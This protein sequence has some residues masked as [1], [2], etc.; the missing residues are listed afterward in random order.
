M[1]A[2]VGDTDERRFLQSTPWI[3]DAHPQGPDALVTALRQQTDR[4]SELPRQPRFT[5]LTML[6]DC[7]LQHL[8]ELILSVRCQSYQNW[9]LVLVDDGSTTRKR[10]EFAQTWADRDERIHVRDIEIPFGP[11][12][13]KNLAMEEATGDFLIVTDGDGVLHPMALGVFARHLNEDPNVN[14][15]F[16]NEAEIDHSSTGLTNFL[17]KPPLD[18]FT[19]LRVPYIGRLCAMGRD[20]VDRATQGGGPIFRD[21]YDGIEE[22]DLSLRLALTSGF[23]SRHVPL[24]TYYRRAGSHGQ[25][26]LTDQK[27]VERRR[28][29]AEEFIPRVYPGS[30]WSLTVR[31]DRD[32][33][34]STSIWLKDVPGWTCPKLLVVIPFKDQVETTIQC[35]ESIERQ[36]HQLDVVVALVNNQSS[37]EETLPRLRLWIESPRAAKYQIL[38]HDGAFN[39][40]RLNNE[41]VARL[42]GDRDLI[43]LLNNDVELSTPQTLETLAMQLLADRSIGFVGI[44]LVYPGGEE[45][46]HG[47]VRVGELIYGSGFYEIKHECNAQGFVDAD[48]ISLGVTFACAMTRRRTYE[49]L[50]GL[51]ELYLPNGYGDVDMC[52]RALDAGFRNYYL[53]SLTAI[54]HESKSRGSTNEDI[55]ISFLHQRKGQT[56]ASWRHLHLSRS[57]RYAWPLVVLRWDDPRSSLLDYVSQPMPAAF[58]VDGTTPSP[59][60]LRYRLA[61]RL[62]GVLKLVFGPLHG[63]LRTGVSQTFKVIRTV[64]RPGVVVSAGR[65]LLGPMPVVGNVARKGLRRARKIRYHWRVST[66][67]VKALWRKPEALRLL[68]MGLGRGGGHGLR[69]SIRMLVPVANASHPTHQEWFD[70][71]RPS[72]L[73]LARLRRRRWPAHAPKFTVV[74]PVYN[75][76]EK[77]LRGAVESVIAQT[78][79][80]W[81]MIC[82]NDS[83]TS[84]HIRPTLDEFAA[85]DPRVKVIHCASNRGVSV[86]TNLGLD[87]ATGDYIAFMDHDDHL[88]PHA[89]HRFAE[90]VLEDHPDM[91]YS[92]EAVTEVDIN[93]VQHVTFRPS[94]SYDYYLSYPLFVHLVAAR[95]EIVRRIG[96]LNEAMTISQ[97]IDYGLRLIEA[98]RN[99]THIPEV[100]YRWRTHPG[101]LGHQ[102]KNK[103]YA[104][105]RGA[106]ERHFDRIGVA[107]EFDD[108]SHF[109]FRDLRFALTSSARVAIVIPTKDQPDRLRACVASLLCTVPPELAEII[110]LDRSSNERV[111]QSVL[112]DLSGR[113]RILRFEGELNSSAL[114]NRGAAASTAA[115]HY[116]FLH[117][118]TEA[119][120]NGWLEHMLGYAHRPD[121]GVVGGTLL[122]P[123]E[124]IQ[125]AGAVIGLNGT[126][127]H[128]LR[129]NLFRVSELGRCCGPN[130]MLLASRDTSAVTAACLL[131]R[132]DVFDRLGG[133]DEGLAARYHDADLCL[134]ARS[135][136]YKVIQD[137]YAVLYH[138]ENERKEAESGSLN[139]NDLWRF[140]AR[141]GDQVFAGD[142]FY[143][144]LLS[145]TSADMAL[146][147]VRQFS[148]RVRPR[149]TP[150]VL[151]QRATSPKLLRVDS[152]SIARPLVQHARV[153]ASAEERHELYPGWKR[154]D[155]P[156]HR[157]Q[158]GM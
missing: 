45:I 97:D 41:A 87:Q 59:L 60:P 138:E 8:K 26:R 81:E 126:H 119:F 115:T 65:R 117:D 91:I 27:L 34:A 157:I 9:E 151:P 1:D 145:T 106:L 19:L 103:V 16:A 40:A 14:F 54:H 56:I 5:L 85:R 152:A 74:T 6:R 109:N 73:L 50:G 58:H 104:M 158:G 108:R 29:L 36:E 31:K 49:S 69:Q 53:G 114:L 51:D 79:P 144:P 77:W 4:L 21:A 10:L 90:A 89:L 146:A 3:I 71:T 139:W 156:V 107:A 78:Y 18:L 82:V 127:D 13:A 131:A 24:F 128:V 136:G 148:K 48:R 88:E 38:D 133:F 66:G 30:S 120:A 100:L 99:I 98:S 130:G 17:T 135:L 154:D 25:T 96:G 35:L 37:E 140:L 28:R 111:T 80:H 143:S 125:H 62:N 105:T 64:R 2:I 142:P 102:Q 42:G 122:Y 149:T 153:A 7:R 22:H 11:S 150:I 141:H 15:I 70:A 147:P 121:V 61:D 110:I 86:A 132:A 129:H 75:V 83:S 63:T 84:S 95:T 68:S 137:A 155:H 43:C 101:S 57:Y 23:N 67:L 20:L 124:T 47:G 92:D 118:D 39:F 55:E 113:H 93:R 123:D 72:R 12:W 33:L 94:F 44:K 116:L 52:L 32:P 46:Q 134:R 76:K 112:E